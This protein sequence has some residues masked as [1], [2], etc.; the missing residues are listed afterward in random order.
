MIDI[1]AMFF[2]VVSQ[3]KANDV[4]R[5]A[6]DC[7]A[8]SGTIFL[9]EGTIQNKLLEILGLTEVRKE[10]LMISSSNEICD[11]LHETLSEEFMFYKKNKGIA[12]TIPFKRWQLQDTLE[13]QKSS[14]ENIAATHFC[15]LTIVDKGRGKACINAARAAGAR[16]GTLIHA[17]GA[18]IP[19][20]FYFPLV[21][22]PQKEI[23][24]VITTKEKAAP[25]RN[26]IFS[27]L[28]LGKVGNG[29]IFTLPVNRVSGIFEGVTP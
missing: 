29:I 20:E 23:V 16:G 5:K 7:G 26:R 3:G 24:M 25:I 9:G 22:E 4:L 19:A 28:E 21:I 2:V 13:E 10:I 6:K 11:K 17:R 1:D 14:P 12:F 18:G 8:K 27:E 15:I